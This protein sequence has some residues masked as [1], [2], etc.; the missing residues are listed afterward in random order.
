MSGN[1]ISWAIC[2]SA[3][4]SRQI[5]T[6]AP[7]HSSFF[8]GRMPFLPTNQQRQST[9]GNI[10]YSTHSVNQ[11]DDDI[12]V[13]S[14]TYVLWLQLCDNLGRE[15]RWTFNLSGW[16]GS[17]PRWN[18]R[19]ASHSKRRNNSYDRR[20]YCSVLTKKATK[21]YSSKLQLLSLLTKNNKQTNNK[22]H[23][24]KVDIHQ[25]FSLALPHFPTIDVW[26]RPRR[27]TAARLCCQD[28]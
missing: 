8:T 21:L 14:V 19:T 27:H 22:Q 25:T 17:I 12:K 11:C 23:T 3:S 5:T 1:G 7:H 9:K 26:C 18:N 6:P 10:S 2:K 13:T 4:R 28:S 20:K 16:R 15:E 24:I